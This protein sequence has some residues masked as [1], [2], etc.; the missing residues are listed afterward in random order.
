M[1]ESCGDFFAGFLVGALAGAAAA[2]LLTPCSGEEMRQRLEQKGIELKQQAVR[3][4]EEARAQTQQAIGEAVEQ[5]Q[6]RGRIVLAEN[7]RK[8]Q[9]AVQEAQ[10]RLSK[11]EEGGAAGQPI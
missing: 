5:V 8:A 10:A 1:S 11:A 2:L 9:Q 3:L 6:E 7:V 4:A